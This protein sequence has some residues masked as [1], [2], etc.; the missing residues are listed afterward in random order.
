MSWFGILKIGSWID[1]LTRNFAWDKLI[2][3]AVYKNEGEIVITHE[4]S[5][6]FIE[7][8]KDKFEV[9]FMSYNKSPTKPRYKYHIRRK[10]A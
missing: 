4:L 1:E 2:E 9:E 7:H 6:Q 10:E 5:S 3:V 8:F